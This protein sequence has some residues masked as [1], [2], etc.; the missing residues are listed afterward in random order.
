M[1][2][3]NYAY[4]IILYA[5]P[6]DKLRHLAMVGWQSGVSRKIFSPVFLVYRT[7]ESS[8]SITR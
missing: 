4:F 6:A 7:G 1:L 2:L 5:I 3:L 8:Y